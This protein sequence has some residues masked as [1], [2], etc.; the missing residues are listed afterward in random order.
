MS[1]DPVNL[2]SAWSVLTPQLEV[3]V[4]AVTPTLYSELDEEFDRFA[5]HVL[6]SMHE[7]AADWPTWEMHPAGDEIV[8]LVAGSATLVLRGSGGDE[9][10]QLAEPGA[11]AVVPRGTWHTARVSGPATMLFV[12]PGEGTENRE[13]P[14]D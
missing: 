14:G 3:L 7:F 5:G 11:F 6:V 13:Q 12:T 2:K 4:K 9:D 1:S 10:V 8:V